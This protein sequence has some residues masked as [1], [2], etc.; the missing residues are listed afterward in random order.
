MAFQSLGEKKN[1]KKADKE[2]KM[3]TT[4]MNQSNKPV[5]EQASEV[6]EIHKIEYLEKKQSEMDL[7]VPKKEDKKEEK[8]EN[9]KEETNHPDNLESLSYSH[10]QPDRDIE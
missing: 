10:L 3:K 8:K 5:S 6:E 7:S 1:E 4:L 9:K 2:N